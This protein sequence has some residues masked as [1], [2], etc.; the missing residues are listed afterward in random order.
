MLPPPDNST[1]YAR[2]QLK[3]K[4]IR[5]YDEIVMALQM[6]QTSLSVKK[7]NASRALEIAMVVLRDHP[8]FY[9]VAGEASMDGFRGR[10]EFTKH[11]APDMDLETRMMS[12]FEGVVSNIP[13]SCSD[14][15]K[16]KTLFAFV[17]GYASYDDERDLSI[18]DLVVA[19][20][21]WGVFEKRLAVCDGFSSAL[22]FL[23]QHVG[24]Q[25]Y[26]LTGVAASSCGGGPHSW[27]LARIDGNYYHIDPTWAGVS[28]N[29]L[30]LSSG[31]ACVNYDY[32][33]LC[34]RDIEVTHHAVET[35]PIP[36]CTSR[37]ANYYN[38]EGLL[39]RYW[40]ER[41]ISDSLARQFERGDVCLSLRAATKPLFIKLKKASQDDGS[42][43]LMLQKG[44]RSHGS[45][46]ALSMQ[47]SY[48]I[49]DELQTIHLIPQLEG[50]A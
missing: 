10:L 26:R 44:L 18:R 37:I 32:L 35:I 45:A 22:Q 3:G 50:D 40:D 19:H 13:P 31:K 8:E 39:M 16:A 43:I 5:L 15:T 23:L 12:I 42:L 21:L 9:W 33:C 7:L 24:I 41:I 27:V 17:A 49:N 38:Q 25:A 48:M 36:A 6:G 20:S 1:C 14:Y 11:L 46:S 47:Y 28:F 34:D 29:E 2:S 30:R 4:E